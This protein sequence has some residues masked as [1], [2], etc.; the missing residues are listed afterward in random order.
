MKKIVPAARRVNLVPRRREPPASATSGFDWVAALPRGIRSAAVARLG[1]IDR[2]IVLDVGCGAGRIFRHLEK[3]GGPTSRIVG[4]D[5]DDAMLAQAA[6]RCERHEWHN[7]AL[8]HGDALVCPMPE[9]IGAA[10]FCLSYSTMPRPREILARVWG[11][12]RPGGRVVVMDAKIPTGAFGRLV[13]A[14]LRRVQSDS[15][16]GDPDYAPWADLAALGARVE[17]EEWSFGS[18]FV[19]VG[20]K[21]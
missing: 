3:S 16:I 6:G 21:E 14:G 10:I 15:A 11:R 1:P 9:S 19:A 4:I 13:S 18:Y 8:V 12:L 20:L 2:G 5:Q 7:I 17:M